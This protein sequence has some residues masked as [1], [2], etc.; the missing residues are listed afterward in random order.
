MISIAMATYN[1]G[2]YLQKQLD[3]IRTQTLSD[4]EIIIC[5]DCSSDDTWN[6][7]QRNAALD[8]RIRC[9]RNEVNLGFKKIL[10]K[11]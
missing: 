11:R 10:K 8:L 5:D 4:I 7:L 6:I 2:F 1:G 9:I 3:S